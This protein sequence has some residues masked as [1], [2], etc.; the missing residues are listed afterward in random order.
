M[1]CLKRDV[2]SFP[3]IL[4]PPSWAFPSSRFYILPR[5]L[6]YSRRGILNNQKRSK[7]E[8]IET[9]S[10]VEVTSDIMSCRCQS[11]IAWLII[12]CNFYFNKRLYQGKRNNTILWN[13]NVHLN[14]VEIKRYVQLLEWIKV[15]F[16]TPRDGT[17]S[18]NLLLWNASFARRFNI[19]D[20]ENNLI[21]NEH[22]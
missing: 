12:S 18:F 14:F 15:N 3:T 6:E 16:N 21:L 4:F 10:E 2:F 1:V 20:F 7:R 9:F 13:L 19:R 8:K 5:T 22:S 17:G 11:M